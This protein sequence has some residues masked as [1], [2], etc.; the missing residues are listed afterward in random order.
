MTLSTY[1]IGQ[2]VMLGLIVTIALSS[3]PPCTAEDSTNC[4]WNAR[5]MGNGQGDSY[6]TVGDWTV[7]ISYHRR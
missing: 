4:Y 5:T 3:L 6:L 2:L 1:L 7:Y